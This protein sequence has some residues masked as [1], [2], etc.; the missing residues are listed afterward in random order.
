MEVVG[1]IAQR[2]LVDARHRALRSSAVVGVVRREPE[3]GATM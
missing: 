3:S 1:R 2:S